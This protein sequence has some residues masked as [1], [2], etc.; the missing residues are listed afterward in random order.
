M[1]IFA[2]IV[3]VLQQIWQFLS[4]TKM[5]LFSELTIAQFMI[6]SC[7]LTMCINFVIGMMSHSDNNVGG[8]KGE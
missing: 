8:G 4:T 7:L 2:F 1:E 3:T 6:L 5:P